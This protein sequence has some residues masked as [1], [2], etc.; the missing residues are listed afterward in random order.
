MAYKEN[1]SIELVAKTLT[2]LVSFSHSTVDEREQRW[3]KNLIQL[4]CRKLEDFITPNVSVKAQAKA[5]Q[6]EV[7]QLS[8]YGWLDQKSKMNDPDRSIFHFEHILTVADLVD[9]LLKL[10]SEPSVDSVNAVI[11]KAAVAW[12]LKSEDQLLN[13]K[14]YKNKRPENPLDAYEVCG[15]ELV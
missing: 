4:G 10:G 8:Q 6:M 3:V 5:D 1:V 15:I 2:S 13:E 9:R 7:G 11:E 12:I 14:G